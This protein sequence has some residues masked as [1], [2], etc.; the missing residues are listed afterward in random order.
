MP[1]VGAILC[2][3]LG[4]RVRGSIAIGGVPVW[5]RWTSA[6]SAFASSARLRAAAVDSSTIAAFCCVILSISPTEVLT[7]TNCSA[8]ALAET[9]ISPIRSLISLTRAL[10]QSSIRPVSP[11][12]AAP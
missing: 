10:I 6:A 1:C 7:C 2:A 9:E 4:E 12:S 11:T 8:C 3:G 5:N